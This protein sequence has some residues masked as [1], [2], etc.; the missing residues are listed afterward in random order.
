[1]HSGGNVCVPW[2]LVSI[3]TA[4][5]VTECLFSVRYQLVLKHESR[6]TS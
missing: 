4:G 5:K 2:M 3:T 1:M 6:R